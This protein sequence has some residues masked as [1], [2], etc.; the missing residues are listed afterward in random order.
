MPRKTLVQDEDLGKE[1]NEY[2]T[3]RK[4]KNTPKEDRIQP[5]LSTLGLS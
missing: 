5:I 1:K 4:I 2:P 3:P